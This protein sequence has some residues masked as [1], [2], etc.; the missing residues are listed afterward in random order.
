MCH[1][2]LASFVRN[3]TVDL[4]EIVSVCFSTWMPDLTDLSV[5][6]QPPFILMCWRNEASFFFH[7]QF[8]CN[9]SSPKKGKDKRQTLLQVFRCL[10]IIAGLTIEI[11]LS[12]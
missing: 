10:N 12:F 4:K 11:Q 2:P 9:G 5:H 8:P 7:G 1:S 3:Y 6:A